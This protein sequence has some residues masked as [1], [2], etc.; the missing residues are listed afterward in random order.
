MS[1][2]ESLGKALVV[3]ADKASVPLIRSLLRDGCKLSVTVAEDEAAARTILAGLDPDVILIAHAPPLLD[4]VSVSRFIRFSELPARRRPIV[5]LADR[6]T[7]P[8]VRAARDVGVDEVLR[9]PFTARD[10]ITHVDVA[11]GK[12]RDWIE[13]IG[14]VGPDRRRFNAANDTGHRRRRNDQAGACPHKSKI[15]QALRIMKAAV[16]ALDSEPKQALRSLYA[17]ADEIQEASV[18][19]SDFTM[20]RAAQTL[21]FYLDT[22]SQS[23]RFDKRQFARDLGGMF[24][25]PKRAAS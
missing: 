3:D 4:A 15:S 16:D 7:P 20:A 2:A 14:Y 22:A 19:L 24:E 21:R 6:P 8:E 17:Q 10:L 18:A 9:K 13:A 12:K 1:T 11:M 5:M 23:G 25:P